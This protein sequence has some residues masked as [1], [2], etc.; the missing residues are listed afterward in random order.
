MATTYLSRLPRQ[1]MRIVAGFPQEP[2]YY[3]IHRADVVPPRSLTRRIWP[4]V[5]EGLTRFRFPDGSGPA[6]D[7]LGIL[8]AS[9][10]Q[11]LELMDWLRIVFLQDAVILRGM[12][13][14]S[15]LWRHEVFG[16]PDWTNFAD[17]VCHDY[18]SRL[19]GA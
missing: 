3:H 9:V 2:G 4:W 16:L 6:D 5:D 19:A 10:R 11:F 18:G 1:F 8:D 13:P 17:D 7:N 12:C 14:S 15:P